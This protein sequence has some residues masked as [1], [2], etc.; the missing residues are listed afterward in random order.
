MTKETYLDKLNYIQA[1]I[2]ELK[3]EQDNL[4]Q[5][6]IETNAEFKIGEKIEIIS[7]KN[8]DKPRFAFV[9]EIKIDSWNLNFEY[10]LLKCKKDGTA[11]QIRDYYFGSKL[12]KIK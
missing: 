4:D 8:D 5:E 11:S 3:K 1:Q 12:K 2:N 7:E 9:S 10:V 6:Y